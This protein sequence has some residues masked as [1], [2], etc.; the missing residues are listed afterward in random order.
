MDNLYIDVNGKLVCYLEV[1]DLPTNPHYL[2]TICGVGT[3]HDNINSEIA[4]I[5]D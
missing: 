5:Y 2:V 1:D 4:F 3:L